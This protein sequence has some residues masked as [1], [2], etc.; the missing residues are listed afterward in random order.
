MQ[1]NNKATTLLF[2]NLKVLG[3]VRQHARLRTRGGEMLDISRHGVF[4]GLRR[5]FTGE[6]REH[7]LHTVQTVLDSAFSYIMMLVERADQA[8]TDGTAPE[9]ADATFMRRLDRQLRGARRGCAALSSTYEGDSVA[10]ARLDCMVESIDQH[11]E[12]LSSR[13]GLLS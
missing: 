13:I 12:I 9:S 10:R 4:E 8:A 7:N 1:H 3:S 5:W 2:C 11:L 6:S